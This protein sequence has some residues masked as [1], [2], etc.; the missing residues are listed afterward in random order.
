MSFD[1]A[2]WYEKEVP[3]ADGAARIYD[4]FT[5]GLTGVAEERGEIDRFYQDIVSIFPDITEGNMRESPWA[6]PLYRTSECV[7]AAISWSRRDELVPTLL[8]LAGRYGLTA[9]DPQDQ[10]VYRVL[11]V[12]PS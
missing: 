11:R 3:D 6:S 7:I 9:Y 5:D 2:F 8:T 1:L 12:N 4:Q 10:T